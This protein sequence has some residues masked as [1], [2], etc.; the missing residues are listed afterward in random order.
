MDPML[1]YMMGLAEI[2]LLYNRI[3]VMLGCL[4]VVAMRILW[5][6]Y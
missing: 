5:I 1:G 3:D 4:L 6:V 2:A